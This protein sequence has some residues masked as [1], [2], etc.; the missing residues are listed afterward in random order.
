MPCQLSWRSFDDALTSGQGPVLVVIS[1]LS[2]CSFRLCSPRGKERAEPTSSVFDHGCALP[3]ALCQFWQ[4]PEHCKPA[5]LVPVHARSGFQSML[6]TSS[7]TGPHH[8]KTQQSLSMALGKAEHEVKGSPCQAHS[9]SYRPSRV[10]LEM[11][12]L[13]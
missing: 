6:C 8:S 4:H 12:L 1:S 10:F 5:L 2:L 3:D 7:H 9:L 11:N 13:K